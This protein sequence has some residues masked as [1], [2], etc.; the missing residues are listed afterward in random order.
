[1]KHS[2]Y[3]SLL[4]RLKNKHNKLSSRFHKSVKEGEFQ[5]QH[6]RKRKEAVE[7]LKNIE[8]RISDLGAKS[9]F[10][11]RLN[12]KHWAVA[13]AMG[14]VVSASAQ[15]KNNEDFNTRLKNHAH[16]ISSDIQPLAQSVFFDPK[17]SLGASLFQ[18]VHTGDIDGDGDIDAIYVPYIDS[19]LILT[20]TGS[21]NFS[22]RSLTTVPLQVINTSILADFDGDGDLDLFMENGTYGAFTAQVWLNDGVGNFTSQAATFPSVD[23][24]NDVLSAVDIDGDGDLD[25]VGET[26][27]NVSPYNS[28][29]T[30]FENTS[31]NFSDTTALK[32]SDTNYLTSRLVSVLDVDGDTDEDIVYTS[33]ITSFGES[34]QVFGNDGSGNFSDSGNPLAPSYSFNDGAS[35]LDFDNDGDL[36][37]VG[38]LSA[39]DLRIRPFANDGT[40]LIDASNNFSEGTDVILSS[41]GNGDDL[42]TTKVDTDNFDDF[43]AITED[44][45]FVLISNGAG[46]FTEQTRFA[47]R[48]KPADLDG[49]SDADLFYFDGNVSIRDNQGSG[50]F[51]Q[52]A[53]ILVISS[54]YDTQ[55]VDLDGD[56]D[57]DLAQG[58]KVSRT[59]LNDG[60]GNFTPIQEFTTG[61]YSLAFGDLDG[62]SDMDMVVGLE[63]D[64]GYPGFIIYTNDG[65][66]NMTYNAILGSGYEA[67]EIAIVD[68]DEDGD[69]DIVANLDGPSNN[70]VRI[71]DNQGSL[72]FGVTSSYLNANG[73]KMDLENIDGDSDFDIVMA[74]ETFGI[75]TIINNNGILVAGNTF[76]PSGSNYHISDVDIADLDG[77]GDMDVFASNAYES[78]TTDCYVFLNDGAGTL[79]DSG[80]NVQTGSNYTS[81]LGDIDGDGDV[82]LITGG[83]ISYPSIWVNDGSA[84]FAFDHDI[85]TI[86]TEYSTVNIGDLDGDSDMDMVV[87]DYYGGTQIFFNSGAASLLEADANA[88][89]SIFD[90]M[91]GSNWT[92]SANWGDADVST[93][94]GV[95]LNSAQDRVE[96]LQ[97][98]NN[99]LV[100][101]LPA[102]IDQLDALEILDLSDNTIDQLATN[103]SGLTNA[104]D[105][106]LNGNQ[107]DFADLEAVAGVS[108]LSYTNQAQVDAINETGPIQIPVGST[109]GLT[110]SANGS[111]NTY[112]WLLD[113]VNI[114]GAT[115]ASYS[116]VDID[117][118]KMGEYSIEI[119][120]SIATG[121]TL[122]TVPVEVLATAVMTVNVTDDTETLITENVNGY[123]LEIKEAEVGFDTL[124]FATQENVSSSFS[125]PEVVLGDFLINVSSDEDSYVPTYFGDAFLWDEADTLVLEND[126]TIQII[127]T[128]T[129]PV[130]TA[131]DGDGLVNGV[132]DEDF[133]DDAS[134]I[135]ARRRASKRRCG[136]R[137]K[138]SGGRTGQD[139][140]EFEL[141]AYGETNDDGEFEYGFLPQGTY[142]FFVEYPGIP[143][144]ESAFVQFDIGEAGVGDNSFKLAVFASEDGIFIE[145][146]LG[147]TSVH[148]TDFRIFP[149][150]TANLINIDYEQVK[151]GKLSL[152]VFDIHGKEM[153]RKT[154]DGK[155]ENITIDISSFKKGQYIFRVID[156]ERNDLIVYKIIKN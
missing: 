2:L 54:T 48:S 67:N 22:I 63:S 100:G 93:W 55:L 71:Y 7:R 101:T 30:L 61:V 26:G 122:S 38:F 85:P 14:V 81:F 150:P 37:L 156:E 50:V 4:S 94:F 10:R 86:V 57:L 60:S 11:P 118:S 96:Q 80:L 83:Y 98:P 148:F 42:F 34:I 23:L 12:Y 137:R 99:G 90:N 35:A 41:V 3:Q 82:D 74:A 120:N 5:K 75:I 147:L 13:L 119:S 29:V 45:T 87:S 15:Q 129:P 123:I 32:G 64:G 104:L 36:D 145:L 112:Q 88:L 31:F 154:L 79:T 16:S 139:A 95:I 121:V 77:D 151:S 49:D 84:N 20:N 8:K 138:R 126:S 78:P 92:N 17:I 40:V 19:P 146:V 91:G 133:E 44:S 153:L 1:M 103:F 68:M 114:A 105:I 110:S 89:T 132:I 109:Q 115:S 143:L 28:Y 73:E 46:L 152:E 128:E 62:D 21:F 97:L 111:A 134:R 70:Y 33:N 127:I 142:R 27:Q 24:D 108:V 130:L 149:N 116:I 39:P 124:N 9:G 47:G 18:T 66:G 65:S 140:D 144:D 141:I 43:V 125:F 58:G 155:Q 59:M 117:R 52:G 69:M 53:D 51:A 113:G 56:G 135:D 136:L 102:A 76:T 106:N 72:T 107:L 6:F 131:A 25:I